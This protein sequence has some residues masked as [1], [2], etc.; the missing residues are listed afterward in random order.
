MM[1]EFV[2]AGIDGEVVGVGLSNMSRL[3]FWRIRAED[4]EEKDIAGN[5]SDKNN[6]NTSS[7]KHK[8]DKVSSV[9]K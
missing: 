8:K 6:I 5:Q 2:E 4:R 3:V 9:N 1:V 7:H